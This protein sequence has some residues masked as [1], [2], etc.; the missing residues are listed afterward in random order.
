[1]HAHIHT[2]RQLCQP[3]ILAPFLEQRTQHGGEVA[4]RI[5]YLHA[6]S[7]N[8]R[9]SCKW[10]H[11]GLL[12]LILPMSFW[13]RVFVMVRNWSAFVSLLIWN[14]LYNGSSSVCEFCIFNK[15]EKECLFTCLLVSALAVSAVWGCTECRAGSTGISTL[16]EFQNQALFFIPQQHL[17]PSRLTIPPPSTTAASLLVHTTPGADWLHGGI[18]SCGTG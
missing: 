7:A 3:S 1:M 9:D 12:S 13:F 8:M 14:Y 10:A 5:S 17:P 15:A 16:P 11:V 2:H 6:G 18:L 4:S